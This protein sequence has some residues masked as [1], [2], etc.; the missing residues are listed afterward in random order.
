MYLVLNSQ[1]KDDSLSLVGL[2]VSKHSR[3]LCDFVGA[4]LKKN[5]ADSNGLQVLG[6]CLHDSEAVRQV[7]HDRKFS[8]YVIQRKNKFELTVLLHAR[9]E[10]N[11]GQLTKCE[12]NFVWM[13]NQP[14]HLTTWQVNF[15]FLS[16]KTQLGLNCIG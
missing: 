15:K 13:N 10:F 12:Y 14:S 7:L 16:L 9:F 4:D 1:L 8:V 6:F 11:T 2:D 5:R 3:Q